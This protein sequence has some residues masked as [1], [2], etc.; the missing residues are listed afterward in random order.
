MTDFVWFFVGLGFGVVLMLNRK[1][2]RDRENY[3]QVD[4]RIRKELALNKNL[5]ES[6]KKDLAWAKQTIATLK[7]KK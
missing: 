7:G 4:E 5:V 1:E 3:E 6:L 2:Y